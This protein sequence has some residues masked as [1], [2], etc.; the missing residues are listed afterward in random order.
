MNRE[1]GITRF[2][3]GCNQSSL[4]QSALMSGGF[5]IEKKRECGP[6]RIPSFAFVEAAP[7]NAGAVYGQSSSITGVPPRIDERALLGDW[8][9]SRPFPW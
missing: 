8:R 9:N 6:G 5:F 4:A 1:S 3:Q 2:A 7:A